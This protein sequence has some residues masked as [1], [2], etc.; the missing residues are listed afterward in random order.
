MHLSERIDPG[1]TFTRFF[2]RRFLSE[3]GKASGQFRQPVPVGKKA[4]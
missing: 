2:K 3:N 4:F 1:G